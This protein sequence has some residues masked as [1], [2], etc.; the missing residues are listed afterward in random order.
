MDSGDFRLLSRAVVNVI[1]AM[2]ESQ[3][4]VRGMTAWAGFRQIG[5]P[6]HRAPRAAGQSKYPWAKMW[7]LSIDAIT[8]FSVAPLRW[9]SRVA[10]TVAMVAFIASL[11][12][13]REKLV[14]PHSLVLGWTSVMVAISLRDES[15]ICSERGR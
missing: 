6:Y 2:P 13:I 1:N 14:H 3:R 9:V 8:G 7:H 10:L 12:L 15:P 5:I 11:W 4:F